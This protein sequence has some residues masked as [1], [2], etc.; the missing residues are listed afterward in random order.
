MTILAAIDETGESRRVLE[1]GA[2][3]ARAFDEPLVVLH[4][5]PEDLDALE[6]R[7]ESLDLD[8]GASRDEK[9]AGSVAFVG[10]VV[11]RALGDAGEVEVRAEGR[12]GS[13]TEQVLA[14]ADDVDARYVVIGGRQRSPAGKAIFGSSTQSILLRAER[15]VVTVR[16]ED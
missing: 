14:A 16:H 6:Y 12:V 2:D 8:P 4:V 15:P 5:V 11:E 13:P 7:H 9:R 10:S 1:V 3:L